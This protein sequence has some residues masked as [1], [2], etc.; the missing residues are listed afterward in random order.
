MLNVAIISWEFSHLE[1]IS[2][3]IQIIHISANY[4]LY[5]PC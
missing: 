4:T 3:N 1:P 5:L 2:T